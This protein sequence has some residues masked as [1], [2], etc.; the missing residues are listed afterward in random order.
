MSTKLKIS[1]IFFGWLILS[2]YSPYAATQAAGCALQAAA[3]VLPPVMEAVDAGIRKG[4]K[5][6]DNI[7]IKPENSETSASPR[8][9]RHISSR[10][11]KIQPD[12]KANRD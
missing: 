2:G 8:G 4:L 1:C 6:I 11:H 12:V 3:Q 10:V 9:S 7:S 5:E